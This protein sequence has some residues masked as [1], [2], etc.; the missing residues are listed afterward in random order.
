M[1]V[2]ACQLACAC[3]CVCVCVCVRV[4]LRVRVCVRVC[5]TCAR[6]TASVSK[7]SHASLSPCVSTCACACWALW[8][9]CGTKL[10]QPDVCTCDTL[11]LACVCALWN[12]LVCHVYVCVCLSSLQACG[13]PWLAQ[14]SPSQPAVAAWSPLGYANTLLGPPTTTL[15]LRACTLT[16]NNPG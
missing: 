11:F 8:N 7:G 4:S 5:V 15:T 16:S 10:P 3:V 12:W 14:V 1:C 6:H 13:H 9:Y 2:C